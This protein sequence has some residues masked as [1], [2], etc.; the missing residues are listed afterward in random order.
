MKFKFFQMELQKNVI[1]FGRRN[2]KFVSTKNPEK[3]PAG[4]CVLAPSVLLKKRLSFLCCY[5]RLGREKENSISY[6]KNS[7]FEIEKNNIR[8]LLLLPLL[9][10]QQTQ[11]RFGKVGCTSLSNDRYVLIEIVLG[12]T[13]CPVLKCLSNHGTHREIIECGTFLQN[14][15]DQVSFPTSSWSGTFA[16]P[17]N[18]P[19]VI[20]GSSSLEE[21]TIPMKPTVRI[22]LVDPMFHF[23]LLPL[24]ALF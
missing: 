1:L 14:L 8:E 22:L 7:T 16:P 5:V 2:S 9:L 15:C 6:H 10:L 21:S 3:K 20:R 11:L 12:E 13:I 19:R 24:D 18:L 23:Q 4:R 17:R